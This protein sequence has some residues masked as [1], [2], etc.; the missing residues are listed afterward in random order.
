MSESISA[1]LKS[2]S[3]RA[4][5]ADKD[6]LAHVEKWMALIREVSRDEAKAN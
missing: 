3:S 6:T 5:A 4:N 1:P 2:R